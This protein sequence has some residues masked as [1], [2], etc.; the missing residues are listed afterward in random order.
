MVEFKDLLLLMRQSVLCVC[1]IA[2]V[3]GSIT[4]LIT[5]DDHLCF[6]NASHLEV[7]LVQV[8]DV[9]C[10]SYDTGQQ[11]SSVSSG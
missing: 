3:E 5:V 4:Y 2:A 8:V 7:S 6:N 9:K 10:F 1:V 11:H